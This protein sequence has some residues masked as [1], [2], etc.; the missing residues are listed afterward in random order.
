V[1]LI[2][3]FFF[4][5]CVSVSKG[6]VTPGFMYQPNNFHYL[7]TVEGSHAESYF[8]GM[9]GD[10]K[11]IG[12]NNTALKELKINAKLKSNQTLINVAYDNKTSYFLGGIIISNKVFITADVIEFTEKELSEI[13][14]NYLESLNNQTYID[15]NSL[16]NL[17]LEGKDLKG[18]DNVY[19]QDDFI[20]GQSVSICT[21]NGT[22]S[23]GRV[24]NNKK[25]ILIIR[26]DVAGRRILYYYTEIKQATL[27]L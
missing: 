13:E 25:N 10:I 1:L 19:S 8:L 2:T 17:I 18:S 26:D 15:N 27:K 22:L 11:G 6:Y 14:S 12:L 24:L 16:T 7:K 21:N 9:G 4:S 5:S 3:T 23:S 20:I